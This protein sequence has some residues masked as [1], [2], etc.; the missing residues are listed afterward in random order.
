MLRWRLI[1]GIF[2]IAVL[3]GLV[4]ADERFQTDASKPAGVLLIPLALLITLG[5]TQ[6]FLRFVRVREPAVGGFVPY[7]GN[8]AIVA[9]PWV[10]TLL[11]GS[12]YAGDGQV[13]AF[14]FSVIA[15]FLFEMARYDKD[16]STKVTERI[17][18]SIACLAYV[19]LLMSFVVRLRLFPYGVFPIVSMLVVVKLG[20]IGAYTFGRLF[21]RRKLAPRLSPGKTIEGLLGGVALSLVGGLLS[22]QWFGIDFAADPEAF[23]AWSGYSV[24]ICL[25]GVA[26]DLAE[27]LFKR[28]HGL[29][30]SS[31]WLPGFGGVLDM[32]DSPLLA[33]PVAWL[34]WQ[35]GWLGPPLMV[36]AG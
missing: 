11:D 30:D 1:L 2:F 26:G 3:V 8:L 18:L 21:G 17:A 29:K 13:A 7:V 4:W 23:L 25:I 35:T 32:I 22:A 31:N 9:A 19:G 28:D 16:T 24:T 20:D 27:S 34:F 10:A 5:A 12:A 14:A 33:A 6:E 36:A 15:V